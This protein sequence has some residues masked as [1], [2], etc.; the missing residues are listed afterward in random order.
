MSDIVI[1]QSGELRNFAS[2]LSQFNGNLAS[3]MSNLQA[4]FSRLGE[5]WRDPAYGTFSEE[6]EQTLT[7]LRR[8]N[9]ISA[10][11]VSMLMAKADRADAVHG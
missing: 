1:I 3:E 10:D 4:Q 2:Y 9:E 8:F 5:T 11:F 6:L 7:N